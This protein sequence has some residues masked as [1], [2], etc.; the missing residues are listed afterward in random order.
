MVFG[1]IFGQ[2]DCDF[3]EF[4]VITAS[5]AKSVDTVAEL[6]VYYFT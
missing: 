2:M 4:I 1:D 3:T 6:L 5:R